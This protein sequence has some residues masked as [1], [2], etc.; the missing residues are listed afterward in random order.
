MSLHRFLPFVAGVNWS[1]APLRC[2]LSPLQEKGVTIRVPRSPDV[3]ARCPL[4]LPAPYLAL[5]PG[6]V[7]PFPAQ[8]RLPPPAHVPW[9]QTTAAPR[10]PPSYLLFPFR[11]LPAPP[12]PA[13][14][15]CQHRTFPSPGGQDGTWD[16]VA[17]SLQPGGTE[18]CVPLLRLQPAA[19]R[20][21]S[22]FAQCRQFPRKA[23]CSALQP[24]R[25]AL[26]HR[27]GSAAVVS[28][29]GGFR[30]RMIPNP[31]LPLPL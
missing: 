17:G 31:F 23:H 12:Q 4:A 15:S 13:L 24:A 5:T 25:S 30:Q 20:H 28:G 26:R 29:C 10:Q 27:A 22:I 14:A 9:P 6:P 8:H 2:L 18:T 1:V 7:P 3:F 19:L 16:R 21:Q 11:T